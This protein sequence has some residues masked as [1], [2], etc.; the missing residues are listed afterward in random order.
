MFRRPLG[1]ARNLA[2]YSGYY[3]SGDE[4]DVCRL[5]RKAEAVEKPVLTGIWAILKG[6]SEDSRLPATMQNSSL[7]YGNLTQGNLTYGDPTSLS[8]APL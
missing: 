5:K 3:H 1:A 6:S 4:H 7:S 8:R 2:Y